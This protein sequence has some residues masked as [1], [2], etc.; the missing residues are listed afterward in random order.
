M[1]PVYLNEISPVELRGT[2]PGLAYQL[3]TLLAASSAQIEAFFGEMLMKDGIPDY[4][5]TIALLT[6]FFSIIVIIILIFTKNV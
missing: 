5:L 3:G 1:I 6:G 2:F 4:G